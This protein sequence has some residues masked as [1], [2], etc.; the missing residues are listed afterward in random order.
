M[1]NVMAALPNIGGG[2]CSM[3]LSLADPSMGLFCRPLAA[4]TP[5]PNFTDLWCRQLAAIWESWRQVQNYKPSP[6]QWYQNR[7]CTPTPS[8]R[9][10][11]H[12]PWRSTAWP[13]DKLADKQT[14]RQTKKPQRF[15][16][17]SGGWDP[18]PTKPSSTFLHL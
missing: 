1:P 17:L 12:K 4:K 2:L 5:T 16:R 9:N 3:T 8:W 15:G 10:R 11:A 7:F 18:S 13:T 14:D 6:M